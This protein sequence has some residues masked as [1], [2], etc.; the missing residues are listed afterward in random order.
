MEY[1]IRKLSKEEVE[2]LKE[3]LE[4]DMKTPYKKILE[5]VLRC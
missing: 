5:Y 2:L 3:S 1:E 4:R